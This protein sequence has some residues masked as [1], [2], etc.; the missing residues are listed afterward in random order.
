VKITKS[1]LKQIIKEEI[2]KALSER[3]PRRGRIRGQDGPLGTPTAPQLQGSWD[4]GY[5]VWSEMAEAMRNLMKKPSHVFNTIVSGNP[6]PEELNKAA[7]LYGK[8][9]ERYGGSSRDSKVGGTTIYR[10]LDG[11]NNEDRPEGNEEFIEHIRNMSE[12]KPEDY[13]RPGQQSPSPDFI[14][15]SYIKEEIEKVLNEAQTKYYEPEEVEQ[16]LPKI[17]EK[18]ANAIDSGNLTIALE[19]GVGT[20]FYKIGDGPFKP[21]GEISNDTGGLPANVDEIEDALAALGMA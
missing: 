3:Q 12:L 8:I 14:F 21:T 17:Y 10:V 20:H 1:Q 11:V 7:S 2:E 18:F 16:Y 9:W 15:K 5:D 19:V 6:S 4:S 13:Q